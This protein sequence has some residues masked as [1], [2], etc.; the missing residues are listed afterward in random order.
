[1]PRRLISF[2]AYRHHKAR[3]SAVV[4]FTHGRDIYLGPWKSRRSR[5]LYDQLIALW[6]QH[7]R[8]LPDEVLANFCTGEPTVD[9][10][11][12]L[13]RRTPRIADDSKSSADDS[14]PLADSDAGWTL[15]QLAD[16]FNA[17]AVIYYRKHDRSTREA[18]QIAEALVVA[19]E[20]FGAQPVSQFGP[21][22]FQQV[23]DAMVGKGWSRSYRTNPLMPLPSRD[24]TASPPHFF[25]LW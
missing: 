12:D 4:S 7:G 6:L 2:P 22:R 17:H 25:W 24:R 8:T 10:H 18:E 16:E 19:V 14:R 23:R 9:V 20:L 21:L 1:M 11:L 15:R 3:N 13:R 5:E